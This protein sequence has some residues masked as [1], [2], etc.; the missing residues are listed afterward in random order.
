MPFI[1]SIHIHELLENFVPSFHEVVTLRSSGLNYISY[2]KPIVATEHTDV[3][4]KC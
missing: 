3:Q 2:G 4:H 1:R